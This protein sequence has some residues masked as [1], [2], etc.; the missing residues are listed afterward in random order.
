MPTRREA[1]TG[2][3]TIGSISVA[4]CFGGTG[5]GAE[6]QLTVAGGDSASALYQAMQAIAAE[7]N[8]YTDD[9]DVEISPV[10]S[11]QGIQQ[12]AQGEYDMAVGSF[13]V[14]FDRNE[15]LGQ[16]G[17]TTA[18]HQLESVL[19]F[20]QFNG[21]V[22]YARDDSGIETTDDLE[23][24]TLGVGP[25]GGDVNYF[26]TNLFEE[27]YGEIDIEMPSIP[28]TE[29]AQGL[30]SGRLDVAMVPRTDGSTIAAW[31][32]ELYSIDDISLV[33]PT[34]TYTTGIEDSDRFQLTTL[35]TDTTHQTEDQQEMVSQYDE[36]PWTEEPY[37]LYA[38]ET[39][40]E[41]LIYAFVD[42]VWEQVEGIAES[43]AT[44]QIW[45]EGIE[46]MGDHERQG[47]GIDQH[48]GAAELYQEQGL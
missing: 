23:G 9:V 47:T 7:V 5:T 6:N 41:D 42:A 22:Y 34:D 38:A 18:K 8:D 1:L 37:N 36:L 12:T 24:S 30:D 27:I 14:A 40:D 25:G 17:G 32:E 3:A 11:M 19:N 29:L 15:D 43:H 4:G 16:Y 10:P 46:M 31:A 13:T 33:E 20:Y 35:S 26:Y 48:P 28:W 45:L 39:T 44:A 2:L 21:G